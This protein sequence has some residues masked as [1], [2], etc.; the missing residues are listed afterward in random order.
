MKKK[1]SILALSIALLLAACGNS[2]DA[3][4]D[5]KISSLQEQVDE[6][7]KISEEVKETTPADDTISVATTTTLE[8]TTTVSTTIPE[9]TAETTTTSLIDPNRETILRNVCWGDSKEIVKYVESDELFNDYEYYLIYYTNVAGYDAK[10][11]YTFDEDYGLYNA[12]YHL[13]ESY[14][15]TGY[16]AISNYNKIKEVLTAK[17]GVP[18]DDIKKTINSLAEYCDSDGQALELGY[19][20]YGT[21]WEKEDT[22]IN[23]VMGTN[24]YKIF[25]GIVFEDSSFEKPINTSGL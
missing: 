24:N 11:V 4:K 16:Y 5:A 7:G 19:I 14:F 18:T 20:A 25:F 2:S 3:E 1:L 9:T 13:D 6:L 15:D 22:L 17:Y 10:I 21:K 8:T 23:I 12:S